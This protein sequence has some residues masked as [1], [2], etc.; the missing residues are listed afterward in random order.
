MKELKKKLPVFFYRFVLLLVFVTVQFYCVSVWAAGRISGLRI[1]QGISSVRIVFDADSEFDYNVFLLDAP[2][3][4]VVDTKNVYVGKALEKTKDKNNLVG[5]VRVGDIR[6]GQTRIVFD[7]LKP[8]I[9]KKVFMLPPQSTF[10]WRLAIDVTVASER[11]FSKKVG[12]NNAYGNKNLSTGNWQSAP[13]NSNDKPLK[14]N[15]KKVLVIDAGHGGHDPG[16]IGYSGVHEKNITLAMAKELKKQLDRTGKYKVYLTRSTDVFIPLRK[17]VEIA[18]D[19]EA[20]LFMSVHADSALNRKAT[21]LSVYTL[22]EKASDKE[23][24]A[25]AERENKAD[26]IS[27]LNLYEQSKEVSDVLISL[28]QRETRNRSSEFAK[29]LV[30]EMRKSVKLITDTHRFAGFAVLKAPDVPS[31]LLEMGY[32]SNKNEERLLRQ[33][34]YRR[35]LAAST[36]KAINRYFEDMKHKSLF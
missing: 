8:V 14:K 17:R 34:S 22:S 29:C 31:V 13:H 33:E 9:V 27:G 5:Q 26:V 16:A 12:I 36:V 30:D 4:L 21:G 7:L 2:K 6:D 1:G 24:E 3:R 10:K 28:A 32:L 35:K 15:E 18:R 23:A 25:L 19:Y 11:D 20:D